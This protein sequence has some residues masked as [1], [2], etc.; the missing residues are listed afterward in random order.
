MRCNCKNNVFAPRSASLAA[1]WGKNIIE[2]RFLAG[3]ILVKQRMKIVHG[4]VIEVFSIT[5]QFFLLVFQ[6]RNGMKG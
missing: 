4:D 2:G 5:A 1:S 3:R 6:K